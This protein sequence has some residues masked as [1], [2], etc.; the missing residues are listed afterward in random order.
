MIHIGVK[1]SVYLTLMGLNDGHFNLGWTGTFCQN[2]GKKFGL[3]RIKVE[4]W[5][6]NTLS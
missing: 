5:P 3:N 4:V 6:S 1:G 2:K